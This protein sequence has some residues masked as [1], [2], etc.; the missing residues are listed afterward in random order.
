MALSF[1]A[2]DKIKSKWGRWAIDLALLLLC[3]KLRFLL[4]T[5]FFKLDKLGVGTLQP[6]LIGIQLLFQ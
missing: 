1:D 3:H 5:L 2:V 6:T 4:G